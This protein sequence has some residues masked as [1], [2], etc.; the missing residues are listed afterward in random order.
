M[1]P[2]GEDAPTGS[3]NARRAAQSVRETG[4]GVNTPGKA[5]GAQNAK[6]RPTEGKTETG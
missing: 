3:Q 2:R 4:K 5:D 6:K 1:T